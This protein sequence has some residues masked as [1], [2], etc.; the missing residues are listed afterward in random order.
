VLPRH[1]EDGVTFTWPAKNP[2]RAELDR[3]AEKVKGGLI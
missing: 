3:L 1:L 2:P